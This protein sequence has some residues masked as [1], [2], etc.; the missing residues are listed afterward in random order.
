[1]NT[2]PFEQVQKLLCEMQEE[3]GQRNWQEDIFARNSRACDLRLAL[4]DAICAYDA[5]QLNNVFLQ[6]FL[7]QTQTTDSLNIRA[8][9]LDPNAGFVPLFLNVQLGP[10][11]ISFP[12]D[13]S[14]QQLQAA[15]V[16]ISGQVIQFQPGAPA[17]I[18]SVLT[19]NAPVPDV[20]PTAMSS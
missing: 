8:V 11:E 12:S 20:C 16:I 18:S 15:M 2:A 13:L 3:L 5:G 14:T 1:M 9:M 6:Q 17:I 10:P 19:V 7:L 4:W